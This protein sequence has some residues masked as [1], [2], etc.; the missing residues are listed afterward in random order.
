MLHKFPSEH[1]F[2]IVSIFDGF[3]VILSRP[4]LRNSVYVKLV[5]LSTSDT[6]VAALKVNECWLTMSGL[7]DASVFEFTDGNE[8][9][10]T[11]FASD[12]L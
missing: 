11:A 2:K 7:E 8:T 4:A 9:S 12:C 1:P 6:A 3:L 10:A 5:D